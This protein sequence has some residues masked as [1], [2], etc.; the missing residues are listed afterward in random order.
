MISEA[1]RG[2]VAAEA[3]RDVVEAGVMSGGEAEVER[4]RGR[5]E[6]RP[7]QRMA[8]MEAGSPRLRPMGRKRMG[9]EAL[10]QL[11]KMAMEM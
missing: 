8:G 3:V 7:S 1:R 10:I 6:S 11:K 9:T 2:D 4:G 5:G